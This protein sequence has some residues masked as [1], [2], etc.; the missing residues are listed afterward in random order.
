MTLFNGRRIGLVVAIA[1]SATLGGCASPQEKA[2][3][4]QTEVAEAELKLKEE[5]LAM[6]EDYKEC[7]ADA[8]DDKVKA[9]ACD[10]ILKAIE[11]LK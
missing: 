1:L 10:S 5:R 6:L 7:I 2:A 11:A 8:G 3:N 4:A 9:D